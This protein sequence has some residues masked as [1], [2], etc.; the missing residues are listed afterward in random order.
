MAKQAKPKRR[1]GRPWPKQD[2]TSK[3]QRMPAAAFCAWLDSEGLTDS[4]ASRKLGT[5]PGTIASYKAKGASA[6][7]GLACAAISKGLKPWSR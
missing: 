4:D 6:A 5:S 2:R 1:P 3:A 7:V